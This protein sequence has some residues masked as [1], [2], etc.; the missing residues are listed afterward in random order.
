MNEK[1]GFTKGPWLAHDD[2]EFDQVTIRLAEDDHWGHVEIAEV[3]GSE[4]DRI[5]NAQLMAASPDLYEAVVMIR[6]ADD[7]CERDGLPRIPLGAR[8][9]IDAAIARAEGRS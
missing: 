4:S 8:K 7:D 3:T 1:P 9:K 6:D 2:P 5:A